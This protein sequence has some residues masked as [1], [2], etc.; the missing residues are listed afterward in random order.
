ML[1]PEEE[2]TFIVYIVVEKKIVCI[3]VQVARNHESEEQ[4]CTR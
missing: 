1:C 4:S 3:Y 2:A